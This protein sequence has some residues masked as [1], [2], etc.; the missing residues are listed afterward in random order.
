[1]QRF[2]ISAADVSAVH[3]F[4]AR[5]V[6]N[7]HDAEDIAQQTL[8]LACAKLGTCR[9]ENFRPWLLMIARH[10]IVDHYRTRNR[11]RFVEA[12]GL[13]ETEPA[14]QTAPD[15]A[16]A[17]CEPRE[18][19][20]CWIDSVTSR[21]RLEEQVAVLLADMHGYRDKDSAA[22]LSMSVPCFK[23]LLHRT[24]ARL[25]ALAEGNRMVGTHRLGV[26][27]NLGARALLALRDRL[28]AGLVVSHLVLVQVLDSLAWLDE[29]LA[30]AS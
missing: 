9:G 4:V 23:L 21:L 16:R 18:R 19:L 30:L 3:R 20:S 11:F 7:P 1:M 12:A 22:V 5:R 15:A 24:R 28:L 8:L 6:A 25:R 29:V 14:L 27:C 13:A 17:V 2:E 10:L 26:R